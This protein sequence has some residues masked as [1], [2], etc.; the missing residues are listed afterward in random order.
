MALVVFIMVAVVVVVV[1]FVF[2]V[3][4]VVV[5]VVDDVIVVVVATVVVV[6]VMVVV[7]VVA[8]DAREQH[9]L[10]HSASINSFHAEP[11]A[12]KPCCPQS[13]VSS[14]VSRGVEFGT[15]QVDDWG[16]GCFRCSGGRCRDCG[17]GRSGCLGCGCGCWGGGGQSGGCR[18]RGRCRHGGG[19]CR[20]Y[21]V[22]VTPWCTCARTFNDCNFN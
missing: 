11:G 20:D 5:I 3:G 6:A 7:V 14:S 2:V 19:S 10:G 1:V 13:V 12:Q 8:T 22:T 4:A 18:H 15:T 9:V 17:G 16:G 21:T